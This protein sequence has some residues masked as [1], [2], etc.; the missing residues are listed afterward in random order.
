MMQNDHAQDHNTPND[1]RTM[2]VTMIVL[3][4]T[5]WCVKNITY[6]DP[7]SCKS[8][9]SL[10]RTWFI[11]S[12][13]VLF[14]CFFISSFLLAVSSKKVLDSILTWH[15][16]QDGKEVRGKVRGDSHDA[17][18]LQTWWKVKIHRDPV[19]NIWQ[20]C[21]SATDGRGTNPICCNLLHVS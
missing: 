10:H 5:A 11:W 18:T 8:L 3:H 16:Y 2:E 21:C 12:I 4:T 6:E 20:S 7:R 19:P 13:M 15:L 9:C 14:L 17:E 1:D